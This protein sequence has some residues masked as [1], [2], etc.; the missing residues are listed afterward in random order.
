[1]QFF[2][3]QIAPEDMSPYKL[4]SGLYDAL[5]LLHIDDLVLK[6]HQLFF[7]DASVQV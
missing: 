6:T 4:I 1:M 3:T 7:S 2:P 5:K